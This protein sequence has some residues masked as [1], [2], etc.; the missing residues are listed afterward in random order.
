MRET[1][2]TIH[3]PGANA[4]QVLEKNS[5]RS[6]RIYVK[7]AAVPPPNECPTILKSQES[8]ILCNKYL[9][10]PSSKILP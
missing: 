10:E 4:V 8:I 3:P 2:A 7:S 1:K 6:R 9:K 5:F